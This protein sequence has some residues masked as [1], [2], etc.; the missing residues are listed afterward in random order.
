MKHVRV[1]GVQLPAEFRLLPKVHVNLGITLEAHGCLS[2]A[3]N[4]YRCNHDEHLLMAH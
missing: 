2:A 1:Q 3:C 4:H